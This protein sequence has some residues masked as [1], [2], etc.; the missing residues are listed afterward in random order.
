M[1]IDR[2]SDEALERLRAACLAF[3]EA[4]EDYEGVG[5]PAYKVR[6]KIF[7]MR[8][9]ARDGRPSFWFKGQPGFQDV[10]VG[11][12]PERF[13]VPPYVGQHGWVGIWL[14]VEQDLAFIADLIDDS[15][16]LTA[17]KSLTKRLP[18]RGQP[19]Q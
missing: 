7:A 3:P 2:M 19:E 13:F 10:I 15:Y 17:P 9:P 4:T 14:D 11:A 1:S 8:H 18:Q 5:S 16:R 12:E 6:G